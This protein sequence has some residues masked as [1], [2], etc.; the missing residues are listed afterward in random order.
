MICPDCGIRLPMLHPAMPWSARARARDELARHMHGG[1]C[2]ITAERW[3][4]DLD[5]RDGAAR[6][7]RARLARAAD[8]AA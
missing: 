8:R 1:P 4:A 3:E 6:T 5:E 7:V 2:G